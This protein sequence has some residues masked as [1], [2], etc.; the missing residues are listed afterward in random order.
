M[1]GLGAH[2]SNNSMLQVVQ[3]LF[4]F[5]SFYIYMMTAHAVT[6]W[7]PFVGRGRACIEHVP[8]LPIQSACFGRPK[9]FL[10]PLG[11]FSH[12]QT[13]SGEAQEP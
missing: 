7:H 2:A 9:I 4:N 1:A 13:C 11:L 6:R 8:K 12:L 5:Q 10:E 3:H